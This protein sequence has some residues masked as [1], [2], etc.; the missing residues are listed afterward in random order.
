MSQRLGCVLIL[1][2]FLFLG[3]CGKKDSEKPASGTPKSAADKS[4]VVAKIGDETITLNQIDS[5]IGHLPAAYQEKLKTDEGRKYVLDDLVKVTI[6]SKE[7]ERLKLDQ[8]PEVSE[9]LRDIRK[10]ILASE[11]IRAEMAKLAVPG[12]KEASEYY[13][14]NEERFTKSQEFKVR[15]ILVRTKVEAEQVVKELKSG[16]DFAKTAKE[17]SIDPSKASGGN[18]GWV[19]RR[20]MNPAIAETVSKLAKGEISHPIQSP[21]G[22]HILLVEDKRTGKPLDFNQVKPAIIQTLRAEQE[23]KMLDQLRTKLFKEM[24]VTIFEEKLRT[25]AK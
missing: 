21:N 23:Q 13:K 18:V 24:N 14:N 1:V 4:A 15:Q 7:A 16:A 12:E 10:R 8:K 17:K 11:L 20:I 5:A 3:G 22:F 2:F 6:F 19:N 25:A 9:S